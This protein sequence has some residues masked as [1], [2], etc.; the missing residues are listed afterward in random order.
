[1][2][3]GLVEAVVGAEMVAG[4]GVAVVQAEEVEERVVVI[5]KL[6]VGAVVREVGAAGGGEGGVAG[7]VGTARQ[8][9]LRSNTAPQG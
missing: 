8:V 4:E 5:V 2:V 6:G 9:S 7:G 1:V 3:V